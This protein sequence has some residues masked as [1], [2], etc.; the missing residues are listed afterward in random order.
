MGKIKGVDDTRGSPLNLLGLSKR[1]FFLLLD[2][3]VPPTV[4]AYARLLYASALVE[5]TDKN[6][7]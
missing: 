6:K 1:Q 4:S 7:G 2:T 5:E 3:V